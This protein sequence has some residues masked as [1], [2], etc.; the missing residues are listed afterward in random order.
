MTSGQE[1]GSRVGDSIRISVSFPLVSFPAL[2]FFHSFK[3][4]NSFLPFIH[5]SLTQSSSLPFLYS[6]L[7]K[8]T[9]PLPPYIKAPQNGDSVRQH[10]SLTVFSQVHSNT[11]CFFHYPALVLSTSTL[12]KPLLPLISLDLPDHDMYLATKNDVTPVPEDGEKMQTYIQDRR[13]IGVRSP[14]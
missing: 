6:R 12:S 11:L 4:F 5:F 3:H 13:V 2:F 1:Q 10:P 8:W 9:L 7:P 14:N